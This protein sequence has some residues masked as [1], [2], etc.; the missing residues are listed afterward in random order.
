VSQAVETMNSSDARQKFASVL[1]RVYRRESRVLVEKSGIP[2]AAIVSPD[3]LR[4]LEQLDKQREANF[5]IIE[6]MRK[7]FEGV[8]PEEIERET[9]RAIAAVRARNAKTPR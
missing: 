6:K 1:N 8:P 5:A 2:V 4:R 3:D 7:A 9:D